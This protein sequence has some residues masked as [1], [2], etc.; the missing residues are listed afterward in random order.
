[1]H[2]VS[3]RF[4]RRLPVAVSLSFPSAS[5]SGFLELSHASATPHVGPEI[6]SY[7][8]LV[9]MLYAAVRAHRFP[10]KIQKSGTHSMDIYWGFNGLNCTILY[11]I[12]SDSSSEATRS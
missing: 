3:P 6:Q 2:S 9:C 12:P 11:N 5:S 10:D 8:I 1:M 7:L 4:V